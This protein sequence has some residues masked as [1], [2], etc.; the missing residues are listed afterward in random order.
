M[1]KETPFSR[2]PELRISHKLAERKRRKEMRDLF[3]ELREQLPADRGM[4]ASKWE[5]LSKAVD[6]IQHLKNQVTESHRLLETTVRELAIARGQTPETASTANTTWPSSYH[7]FN[8]PYV[9]QATT[10]AAPAAAPAP[11]PQVS[12]PAPQPQAQPQA[13]AVAVPQAQ[14][15]AAAPSQPAPQPQAAAAAVPTPTPAPA[16]QPA[17]QPATQAAAPQPV[18]TQPAQPVATQPQAQAQTQAPKSG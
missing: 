3:D 1:K 2:S 14:P 4:K 12:A 13:A 10:S 15:Q 11:Q 5:I 6:Y 8:I 9:P 7:T 18:A 17:A 16:A